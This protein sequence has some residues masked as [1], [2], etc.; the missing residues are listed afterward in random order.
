MIPSV[1]TLKIYSTVGALVTELVNE[2][3][4][5]GTY[6]IHWDGTDAKGQQVAS[7]V[8]FCRLDVDKQSTTRQ[9]IF[10]E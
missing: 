7:G 1:V 9:M 6:Y 2:Y 3:Q 8:Y 5:A 4:P 10:I